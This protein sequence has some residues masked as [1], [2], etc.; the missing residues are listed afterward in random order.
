LYRELAR[1]FHPDLA[2]TAVEQSYRTAMMSAVNTAYARKDLEALYDL[3]GELEPGEIAELAGIESV[4][5][6]RLREGIMK[7][8]HQRRKA[9]QQ[10]NLLRHEN[11]ARLWRRA[12]TIEGQ[13]QDWWSLVQSELKQVVAHLAMEVDGLRVQLEVMEQESF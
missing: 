10:L 3:A 4:E 2:R 9:R 8:R 1:R 7:A 13:G 6:R 12:Q 11:T 5:I